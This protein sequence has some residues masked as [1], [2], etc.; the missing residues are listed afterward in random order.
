MKSYK[1][2]D[3][4]ILN[5]IEENLLLEYL[6]EAIENQKQNKEIKAVRN[7]P[8]IIP[9]ELKQVLQ[10]N[11]GLKTTYAF[12]PGKQHEFADYISV[13]KR[14]ETRQRRLQKVILLIQQDTGLNDK[15]RK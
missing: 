8:V 5:K 10:E 3:K 7:K 9:P 11:S 12:Y 14:V 4:Y 2:V 15:Y 6:N 13:A 1:T